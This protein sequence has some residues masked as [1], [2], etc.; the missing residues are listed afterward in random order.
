MDLGRGYCP[1]KGKVKGNQFPG[2]KIGLNQDA[3]LIIKLPDSRALRIMSRS[4][5]LAMVLLTLPSIGSILRGSVDVIDVNSDDVR[6]FNMLHN[7]F[8]DLGDEGLVKKGQK[9]LIL[10][11]ENNDHL[12]EDLELL[13]DNVVDLVNDSDMDN[14]NSIPNETFD[15]A[16]AWTKWNS[17][18]IDRVLKIGGI[19]VTQLSNDPLAELKALANYRIV[20]IRRFDK[21]MIGLRKIGTV[22]DELNSR[23]KNILCGSTPEDKKV[24]LK[25]LEDVLFEPPRKALVKSISRKMKFLPELLG[26]SLENYPRRVFI[27]DEKNGVAEWFQ[28]NYPAK[29]QDFEVYNLDVEIQDSEEWGN[30]VPLLG[31][32][33]WLSKNVKEEDYVVMKA[34]AEVVE[35]MI[36]KKTICLVD[37]LFLHCRNQ[38]EDDDDDY[39]EENGSQRKAYWQCLTLY[40]KLIDEGVAVHQW[41]S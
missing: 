37:E 26:D 13:N 29:N 10:S 33:E 25:G 36:K 21:T 9:G 27:S 35:E 20:Y 38:L 7:L 22:N 40:G 19:V 12:A 41:W 28:R 34:E 4:L 17:K 31:A 14:K 16:I 11:S 8:R 32:A 39:E 3:L 30:G 5:F 24:A 2:V 1:K 18:F 6:D 23:K 15:F